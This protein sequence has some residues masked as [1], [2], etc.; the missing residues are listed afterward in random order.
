MRLAVSLMLWIVAALSAVGGPGEQVRSGPTRY[1]PTSRYSFRISA[2]ESGD[3]AEFRGQAREDLGSTDDRFPNRQWRADHLT[4]PSKPEV[5]RALRCVKKWYSW[6]AETQL[7]RPLSKKP[8]QSPVIAQP[9][10]ISFL[11][12]HKI[13]S[14]S[15]GRLEAYFGSPARE[16]YPNPIPAHPKGRRSHGGPFLFRRRAANGLYRA[17][18]LYAIT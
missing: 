4:S 13:D 10:V 2:W 14:A 17:G 11:V 8:R 3:W 5:V 7:R 12:D 9:Q 6:L 1:W 16:P 15:V 18:P